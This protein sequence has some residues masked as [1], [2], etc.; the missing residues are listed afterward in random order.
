ML[1]GIGSLAP[2]FEAVTTE[3]EICFHQWLGDSWGLLFSHPEDYTPVCTTELGVVAQLEQEFISRNIKAIA[4]SIDSLES[5]FGWKTDIE[6]SMNVKVRFPI[7]ADEER[8]IAK[9]YGMIHE[10]VSSTHTVRSVFII[11]PNKDIQLHLT[12]PMAIG[13]NF[14]EILRVIDALQLHEKHQV[15]TPANWKPEKDVLLDPKISE[16]QRNVKQTNH[17]IQGVPYLQFSEDPSIKK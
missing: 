7:I 10:G 5:H 6:K 9:R 3:G 11:G 13:R 14:D 15:L 2:D 17:M 1:L 16:D 8:T 12:Y 4:L